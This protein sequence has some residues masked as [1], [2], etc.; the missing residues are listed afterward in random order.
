M[1]DL[2]NDVDI[3]VLRNES[4]TDALDHVRA[5][6]T[7]GNHWASHRL[8]REGLHR[9][10]GFDDLRNTGKRATCADTGDEG[11]DFSFGVAPDFFGGRFA[12]HLRVG[13]IV[14][15][16]RTKGTW[17]LLQK[18]LRLGDRTTHAA[19]TWREHDLSTEQ[20]QQHPTLNRHALGHG[21]NAT[22]SLRT[23]HKCQSNTGVAGCWFND[24]T[25]WLERT[26]TLR[27]LNHGLADTVLDA[28][29]RIKEFRF[30]AN[31]GIET[32]GHMIEADERRVA[33][34]CGHVGGNWH[35]NVVR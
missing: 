23:S 28:E 22:V 24:Q 35:G 20:A 5:G 30:D 26:I 15:L 10:A 2:I 18:L 32:S 29:K 9:A 14:K 11:I 7:A 33:D 31:L 12:V 17:R 13:R 4:G 8:D 25:T 3:E 21:E 19:R 6:S 27:G 16:T 1:D 34:G